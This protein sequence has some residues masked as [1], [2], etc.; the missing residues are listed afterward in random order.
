MATS[1]Q[2]GDDLFRQAICAW[3]SA[4]ESGV[5]MQEESSKWLR[6][7]MGKSNSLTEWYN[8]GQAMAGETIAKTQ[9]NIDEAIRVINQQA[10]SSIM[11]M[12]K[13]LDARQSEKSS[14][15][16]RVKFAEWWESAMESMRTGSQAMLTANS[17]ILTTWS[18]LV[19]KIN[20]E[21]ADTMTQWAQK[22]AEQAERI[23]KTAAQ[24][25]KDMVK[26]ASAS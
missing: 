2:N 6:E 12:Q 5:K 11:L 19:R 22:T 16:A 23:S 14:A 7:M 3:E 21:T 13:A 8:K 9:E 20:G 10:E 15:D 4:V 1:T 26:Q 25:V 18:D 24:H 17:R